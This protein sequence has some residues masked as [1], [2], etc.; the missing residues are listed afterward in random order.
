[1]SQE[2]GLTV[3]ESKAV[4]VKEW[5][6]FL[7][8]EASQRA[9][10]RLEAYKHFAQSQLKF[11]EHYDVLPAEKWKCKGLSTDQILADPSIK[12]FMEQSGADMFLAAWGLGF[13][14][15]II[16]STRD[17][18]KPFFEYKIKG[19]IV[20]P[21]TQTRLW[22]EVASCSSNEVKY[23]WRWV[24][25]KELKNNP[26]FIGINKDALKQKQFKNNRGDW[27]TKYRVQNPDIADIDNTIFQM[28]SKRAK[29]KVVRCFFNVTKY[30]NQPIEEAGPQFGTDD[31]PEGETPE[32]PKTRPAPSGEKGKKAAPLPS[33]VLEL[34]KYFDAA[35]DGLDEAEYALALSDMWGDTEVNGWSNIKSKAQGGNIVYDYIVKKLPAAVKKIKAER[36]GT[37]TAPKQ[38]AG[39]KEQGGMF[40]K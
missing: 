16:A 4:T 12:K 13:E 10:Q 19:W 39:D 9:I 1:M 28:A 15:E 11:E 30:F 2:Q 22:S 6:E 32:E 37:T 21:G 33:G 17:F 18:D 5:D 25:A 14:P 8:M 35:C 20:H 31:S 36:P 23:R 38:A 24:D 7:P 34:Q 3:I 26:D 40:D 27:E 29:V